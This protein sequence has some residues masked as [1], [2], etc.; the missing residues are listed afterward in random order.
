MH[1]RFHEDDDIPEDQVDIVTFKSFGFLHCHG[2]PEAKATALYEI[3]KNGSQE[4]YE[5]ISSKDEDI[6]SNFIRLATLASKG[7]FKLAREFGND[8]PDDDY[9]T[10]DDYD[11]MLD[12]DTVDILFADNYLMDVFDGEEKSLEEA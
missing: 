1:S 10:D 3:L 5:R 4:A 12:E 8:V 11:K 9:Y 6:R 2:E 7:I